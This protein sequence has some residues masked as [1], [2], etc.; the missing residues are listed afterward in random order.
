MKL[1]VPFLR[2]RELTYHIL[3]A[4]ATTVDMVPTN[5]T[6]CVTHNAVG[7]EMPGQMRRVVAMGS[8]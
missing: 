1:S 5:I 2:D 6:G 4:A 3:N 7:S 8:E